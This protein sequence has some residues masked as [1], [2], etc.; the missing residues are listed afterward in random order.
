MPSAKQHHSHK[1]L[2]MWRRPAV[3]TEAAA[4]LLGGDAGDEEGEE[5]D[6]SPQEAKQG[7]AWVMAPVGLGT[8]AFIW[9]MT[10]CRTCV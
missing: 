3:E 10:P 9:S 5:G 7:W 6:D 1:C 4:E 8:A 2:Y